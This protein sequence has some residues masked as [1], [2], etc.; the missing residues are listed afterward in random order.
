MRMKALT[1]FAAAAGIM[2]VASLALA[3]HNEPSKANKFKATFVTSYA[4]CTIPNTTTKTVP[5]PSCKAVRTS[6]ACGFA[7]GGKGGA[8]QGHVSGAGDIKLCAKLKGLE[9]PGCMGKSLELRATA[10][11]TT[12]DCV[13]PPCTTVDL[14]DFDT[15]LSCTVDTAGSCVI[16]CTSLGKLLPAG[17]GT[18]PV[19]NGC[20]LTDGTA[21]PHV[22]DCGLFIP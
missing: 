8:H 2:G 19:I 20:A 18:S 1:C 4:K 15:G 17:H 21:G 12:D 11:I 6:P 9:I 22:V 14:A 3:T 13:T 16:P 7:P 5:I 10:R